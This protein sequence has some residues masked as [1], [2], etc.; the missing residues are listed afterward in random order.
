MHVGGRTKACVGAVAV[1]LSSPESPKSEWSVH[2][3][4]VCVASTRAGSVRGAQIKRTYRAGPKVGNTRRRT[5]CRPRTRP[6]AVGTACAVLP[7]PRRPSRYI[8]LALAFT[9]SPSSASDVC[10]WWLS[11]WS[12]HA[13]DHVDWMDVAAHT[14]QARRSHAKNGHEYSIPISLSSTTS[15]EASNSIISCTV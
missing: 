4:C 13:V 6:S 8:F 9:E 11:T 1:T 12:P 15:L 5:T 2:V 10:P 7:R 3:S 14:S